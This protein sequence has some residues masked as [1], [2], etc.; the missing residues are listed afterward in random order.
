[1]QL[2]LNVGT[3]VNVPVAFAGLTPAL[4]GLY[5]MNFQAPAGLSA[6][7]LNVTVTQG[8]QTSNPVI[9]AYTP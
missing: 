7:N 3:A 2:T 1:V 4:V 6:G 5:Q 9:L 8:G